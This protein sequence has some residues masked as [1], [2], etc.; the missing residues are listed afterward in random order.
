M[1]RTLSKGGYCSELLCAEIAPCPCHDRTKWLDLVYPPVSKSFVS[2]RKPFER[3]GVRVLVRGRQPW[4]RLCDRVPRRRRKIMRKRRVWSD[5]EDSLLVSKFR[6]LNPNQLRKKVRGK[7][8]SYFERR[9]VR[10]ERGVRRKERDEK[11]LVWRQ[12]FS[13]FYVFGLDLSEWDG[14]PDWVVDVSEWGGFRWSRKSPLSLRRCL[15]GLPDCAPESP[16]P[17]VPVPSVDPVPSKKRRLRRSV[18][19][20]WNSMHRDFTCHFCYSRIHVSNVCPKELT[21]VLL[22]F[23]KERSSDK[24]GDGPP[25]RKVL[26]KEPVEEIGGDVYGDDG[27]VTPLTWEDMKAFGYPRKV[28]AKEKTKA[29]ARDRSRLAMAKKRAS[30]TAEVCFSNFT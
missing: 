29:D 13:Y 19:R 24:Q 22:L 23:G 14:A 7:R 26:S 12:K 16:V 6:G 15:L 8:R 20:R 21:R 1:Y 30:R 25:V 5:N 4:K 2:I 27:S 3:L 17:A 9:R 18:R 28:W 10:A 11:L